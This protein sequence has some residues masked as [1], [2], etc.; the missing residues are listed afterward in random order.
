MESI[1]MV[2]TTDEPILGQQWRH[3]HKG[4]TYGHSGEQEEG[5]GVMYAESNMETYVLPYVK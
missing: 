2:L 1:K 5:E 4:Q 3:R